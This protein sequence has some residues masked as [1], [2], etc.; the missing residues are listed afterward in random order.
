MYQSLSLFQISGDMAA[1]AGKRQTITAQNIANADT[2]GYRARTTQDFAQTYDARLQPQLTQTRN[3][4]IA[5]DLSAAQLKLDTNQA[6]ISINGNSVS[7]EEEM[8]SAVNATRDHEKAL[9]IYRHGLTVL[10]TALGRG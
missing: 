8:V 5:P 9:A 1:H 2:P 10:R 6:Q 4:H 3:G 7:I